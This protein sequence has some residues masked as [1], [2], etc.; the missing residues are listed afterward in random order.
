LVDDVTLLVSELVTNAVTHGE[1]GISVVI[2]TDAD[3]VRVEV[4]DKGNK[5]PD[6]L[7][8]MPTASAPKGRGLAIVDHLATEWGVTPLEENG[9]TVWFEIRRG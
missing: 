1:G 2:A 4:T 7:V 9:K 3:R 5:A 6:D 8:Q